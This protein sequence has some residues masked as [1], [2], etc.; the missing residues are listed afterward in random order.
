[1]RGGGEVGKDGKEDTLAIVERIKTK[2]H[3]IWLEFS[4]PFHHLGKRVSIHHS[5]D[6]EKRD[7]H[8][9]SVGNDVYL[10]PDVWLNVEG[11]EGTDEPAI[12]LG[13][14]CKI[15]RRTVISAKNQISLGPDVLLAPCVLI[16]DHNHEY[17]NPDLPIHE[18]GT[19]EGGR[20]V[21]G[22]NSWLGYGAVVCCSRGK[23]E[24]GHNC[25]VGAHAVVTKSFPAHSVITGN[26][27][28]IIKRFDQSL[29]KWVKGGRE[30]EGL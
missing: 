22:R 20:I 9:I 4:Y 5:C 6:I 28:R 17:G 21:I 27:A 13:D 11:G 2:L 29:E 26:P 18:Q 19:T 10:A 1:M 3:T 7:A 12:V 25:V 16:M 23:L 24:L 15:G 30:D 8:G 14:G